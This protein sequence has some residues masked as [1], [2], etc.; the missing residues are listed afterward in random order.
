MKRISLPLTLASALLASTIAAERGE[1]TVKT[2]PPVVVKTVPQAGDTQVDPATEQVRVTF[3]KEMMAEQ[4]W[5][6]VQI[7]D[8]TFPEITGDIRYLTDK[9][10]CVAPVKLEPGKTY[11][12]WFNRGEHDSFRDTDGRPAVPYLLVFQTRSGGT[13]PGEP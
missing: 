7:S 1:I 9:R 8:E 4:M 3:S 11:V 13:Q 12:I 2:M 5:S 6:W 10:T